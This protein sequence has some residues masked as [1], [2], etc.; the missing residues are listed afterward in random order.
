M[1]A[2]MARFVE[3]Q[4][5]RISHERAGYRDALALTARKGRVGPTMPLHLR[6]DRHGF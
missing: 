6:L 1:L 2:W 4:D 3:N 5:P